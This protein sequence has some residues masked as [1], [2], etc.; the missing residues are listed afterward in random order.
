MNTDA[1][2]EGY[3]SHCDPAFNDDEGD[4]NFA[5]NYVADAIQ[6]LSE[7]D[8]KYLDSDDDEEVDMVIDDMC[9]DPMIRD[10]FSLYFGILYEAKREVMNREIKR[11]SASRRTALI[12]SR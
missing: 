5:L 10:Y 6:E 4:Y 3:Y 9:S 8:R 11:K 7:D 2:A 1:L 12:K